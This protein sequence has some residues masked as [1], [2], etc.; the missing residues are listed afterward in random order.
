[1][2]KAFDQMVLQMMLHF[3]E[4]HQALEL[5]ENELLAHARKQMLSKVSCVY[6]SC[7]LRTT[8]LHTPTPTRARAHARA[9]I[10]AHTQK[11]THTL[12]RTR[13]HTGEQIDSLN[14]KSTTLNR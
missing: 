5:R 7:V 1:M 3:Q 4:L 12:T 8:P 13:A 9:H 2:N 6:T 10:L 14:P 11:H